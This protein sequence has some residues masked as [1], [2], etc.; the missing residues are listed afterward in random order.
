M[1]KTY[2]K[3]PQTKR[4]YIEGWLEYFQYLPKKGNPSVY[5][6]VGQDKIEIK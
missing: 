1:K 4:R 3:A 2:K 6:S 5:G